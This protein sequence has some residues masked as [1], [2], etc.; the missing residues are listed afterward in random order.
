MFE[1]PAEIVSTT[2]WNSVNCKMKELT[3][4]TVYDMMPQ[5]ATDDQ[6]V[7][8]ASGTKTQTDWVYLL[9]ATGLAKTQGSFA[10]TASGGTIK[11]SSE[12]SC[13]ERWWLTAPNVA[14]VQT[15]VLT[16]RLWT[17][18]DTTQ[19]L[20]FDYKKYNVY[21]KAGKKGEMKVLGTQEVDFATFKAAEV[22]AGASAGIVAT[23]IAL[24]MTTVALI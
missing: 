1:D 17:T 5:S 20:A 3:T 19:D 11:R 2:K 13:T 16:E 18:P 8:T 6:T 9:N 15:K 23:A 24:G 10:V 21:V 4:T 14:C 12:D 22:V 7:D